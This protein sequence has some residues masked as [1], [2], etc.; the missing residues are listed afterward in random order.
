MNKLE[1]VNLELTNVCNFNCNFC[2]NSIMRRPRNFMDKDLAIKVLTEIAKDDIAEYVCLFIMGE[3]LLHPDLLEICEFAKSKNLKLKINTNCVIGNKQIWEK[4]FELNID[5]IQISITPTKEEFD[6]IRFGNIDFSNYVSNIKNIV[7]LRM[8]SKNSQSGLIVAV[9]SNPLNIE[10]NAREALKLLDLENRFS[11]NFKNSADKFLLKKGLRLRAYKITKDTDIIFGVLHNWGNS[12]GTNRKVHLAKFGSCN[13][14][15]T[16]IGI[17]SD[18]DYTICCRDYDGFLK[19]GFNAKDYSI[20]EVLNS[21]KAKELIKDFKS[22][23]LPFRYCKLCRGGQSIF[24]WVFNQCYSMVYYNLP[25]Q[26]KLRKFII[27]EAN[28]AA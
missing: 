1:Q 4:L 25:A 11:F 16:Q 27:K 3:P 8:A 13:A 15:R 26:R 28:K 14:L 18:G 23:K 5:V 17:F 22:G 21:K 2:P 19:F 6:S 12:I 20:Q 24:E 9:I 7:N 10:S